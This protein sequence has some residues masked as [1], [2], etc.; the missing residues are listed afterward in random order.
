[1]AVNNWWKSNKNVYEM[2]K[3]KNTSALPVRITTAINCFYENAFGILIQIMIKSQ[4]ESI[5]SKYYWNI[6]LLNH[7]DIKT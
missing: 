4:F 7:I 2:Y 1:M 5:H 3:K 6:D